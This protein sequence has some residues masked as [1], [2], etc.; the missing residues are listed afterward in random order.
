M[1][2]LLPCPNLTLMTNFITDKYLG[3]WYEVQAQETVFQRIKSCQMG[4]YVMEG[5]DAIRVDATGFG[6]DGSP[7][8]TTSVLKIVDAS[9]PAHMV[10]DFVPGVSPPLRHPG[11]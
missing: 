10:T 4:T 7:T 1:V 8:S 6:S 9:N 11:H 2:K 5:P 3:S